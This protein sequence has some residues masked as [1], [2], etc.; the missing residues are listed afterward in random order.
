MSAELHTLSVAE[1]IY[2]VRIPLPFALN[3]V[4]CYLLRDEDGWAIV[5]TG[6]HWP[7]ALDAWRAAFAELQLSPADVSRIVLTHVHPDHYGLAGW[8]QA[9]AAEHGRVVQVYTSAREIQQARLIWSEHEDERVHFGQW[10]I[11]QGM[12]QAMAQEVHAGMDDTR[13][14]TRPAPS[15]LHALDTSEGLLI[16]GRRWRLLEY[17]GHSDGHLLLYDEAD[18]LMLCGDHV[19][20]KITP[21]IGIWTQTDPNPLGNFIASLET[22]RELPVRLAL[23]GHKT[24]IHDWRGRIE[25]LLAHHEERLQVTLQA[26]QAGRHTPYEVSTMLSPLVQTALAVQAGRHTPYEV[27]LAIFDSARFTA[28]EWRFA[29]AEGLAHLDHLDHRGEI[30]RSEERAWYQ[31]R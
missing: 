1:G 13:A 20:M 31:A 23:P 25:E 30:V 6:I 27:S 18:Q 3:S 29:L 14:M 10:L 12:P 26:V 9:Q 4:N 11:D 22:L 15:A 17:G 7:K 28:H 8:W 19:L 24:L 21:N 5:D 2:Q 16:G